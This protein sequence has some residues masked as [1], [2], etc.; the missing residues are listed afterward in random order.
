MLVIG[1]EETT[2]LSLR[3]KFLFALT[4]GEFLT[5][6]IRKLSFERNIFTA[7]IGAAIFWAST[8]CFAVGSTAMC[9]SETAICSEAS[10]AGANSN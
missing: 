9:T 1:V 3:M 4:S 8:E 10:D 5:A 2:W 7:L 6:A